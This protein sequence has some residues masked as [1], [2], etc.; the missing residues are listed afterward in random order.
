M[1]S[2]FKKSAISLLVMGMA[3][4][5]HAHGAVANNNATW[6]PQYAGWFIG[7]EG[8]D[9][10]PMNGDQDYVTT[11]PT[12]TNSYFSNYATSPDYQWSW[13]V[14]GGIK[15]T[16]NEDVVFSWTSMRASD[17]DSTGISDI[18]VAS[19]RFLS[20]QSWDTVSGKVS[21]DLDDA[22]GVWG[23][24]INFNNP[25]SI[26]FGAGL[27][28]VNLNSDMT[29]GAQDFDDVEI[30][31]QS[32]KVDSRLSGIG[33]RLEF[34]MTYHL[35][36]NIGVF[37]NTNAALFVSTRKVSADSFASNVDISEPDYSFST[38][39][40]VIPKLGMKLGVNYTWIFAQQGPC[41]SALTLDAGWQ[42]DSYIH[43]IER[44]E[45][46]L[47]SEEFITTKTSNFG[48]QGWFLGAKYTMGWL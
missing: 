48:D 12:A 37:A 2:L 11:F 41:G 20:S 35:P 4:A 25:W 16:G 46:T 42:F 5:L 28:Y 44:P 17:K 36:Y 13:R 18:G 15:L 26:R 38:R 27:D 10:R 7:A 19:P 14:Y 29:V 31:T 32:V 3:G 45:F 21:F 30:G 33:P 1:K 40:V 43:A 23:H 9:L 34:D 22:Y 6:W 24:T 47:N 39:N 8:L